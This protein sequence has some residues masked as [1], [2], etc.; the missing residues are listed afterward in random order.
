MRAIVGP[1]YVTTMKLRCECGEIISH[2]TDY[3]PY[4]AY[5]IADQD[6]FGVLDAIDQIV[7]DV[8]AGR[9]TVDDAQR[10][11]RCAHVAASRH[12][13]QC[14]KCGRLLVDDLQRKTNRFSGVVTHR[15]NNRSQR[16]PRFRSVCKG[17]Q[18]RG[19]AGRDR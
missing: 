17:R 9:M 16:S 14:G 18:R 12:M 15:P 4:K 1:V 7:S 10:L 3:L 8:A 11:I 19:A 2:Q 13:Y 6:W 5:F